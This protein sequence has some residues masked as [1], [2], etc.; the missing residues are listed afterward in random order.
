MDGAAQ[1]TAIADRL[2]TNPYVG[3]RAFTRGETLY[4]RDREVLDLIDLVVAERIVLL[5]SPSGAGKTSLLQAALIPAL[6]EQ[7]FVVPPIMRVGDEHPGVQ[8]LSPPPNRYV[9]SALSRLETAVPPDDQRS[10]AELASLSFTDY[11]DRAYPPDEGHVVFVI[12]QLEE[13]MTLDPTDAAVKVEFFRQLGEAL[14][15]RRR[16]AVLTLREDFVAALDPYIKAF[17]A[18]LS[19]RYRLDL[20]GPDAALV[21]ITAPAQA[22]GVAFDEEAA[23]ALVDDLRS[24][25][26]ERWGE[27]TAE[28]GPY[29]EPV[30]LQVAARQLWARRDPE[31]RLIGI[32]DVT[33]L[34]DL[35]DALGEYYDEQVDLVARGVDEQRA[36]RDWVDAKLITE[37]GFR[38]QA[39]GGPDG[40][41]AGDSIVRHLVDTHL[42]RSE[43]RRG[44]TWYELAHDRLVGPVRD[45]NA[46]WRQAHLD[47]VELQAALWETEGRPD[48]RLLAGTELE[49]GTRWADA[50]SGDLSP[51]VRDFLDRSESARRAR[52]AGRYKRI[53]LIA[54]VLAL[55][56]A[57]VA[58]FAGWL[59]ARAADD[60]ARATTRELIGHSSAQRDVDP[61]LSTLLALEAVD[62][63]PDSLRVDALAGLYGALNT[64]DTPVVDEFVAPTGTNVLAVA[65]APGGQ[66]IATAGA[67]EDG[68]VVIWDAATGQPLTTLVGHTDWVRAIA[69]APDGNTIATASDDMTAI[70]WDT[71]TGQPLHTLTG[72]TDW[73]RGIAYAPDGNTLAT[74]SDDMAAIIWDAATGTEV[75]RLQGHSDWLNGVAYAPDGN[76]IATA[77]DDTTAMIWDAATGQALTTLTQTSDVTR[78][79]TVSPDGRRVGMAG[80]VVGIYDPTDETRGREL[81]T[82]GATVTALAFTASGE[83][84]VSG[85]DTGAVRLWRA[86]TGTESRELYDA[87]GAIADIAASADER[88]VAVAT[89]RSPDVEIIDLDDDARWQ[90]PRQDADIVDLTFAPADEILAVA[91]ADGTVALWDVNDRRSITDLG[92]QDDGQVARLAS[93]GSPDSWQ[94]AAAYT[95]GSTVVLSVVGNEV[96]PSSVELETDGEPRAVAMSP[97]GS[98]LAV[99][100]SDGVTVA[101]AQG[102]WQP[103]ALETEGCDF[104]VPAGIGY[105]GPGVVAIASAD[106]GAQTCETAPSKAGVAPIYAV[107]VSP[108]GETIVA[109][110]GGGALVPWDLGAGMV[111]GAPYGSE[112]VAHTAW[113]ND[114]DVGPDGE[115][116]ASAG[117]DGQGAIWDASGGRTPLV[118]HTDWVLG[119]DLSPDGSRVATASRDGRVIVWDPEKGEP[120]QEIDAHEGGAWDVVFSPDGRRLASVGDDEVVRIWDARTG[121]AID[122]FR[123]ERGHSDVVYSVIFDPDGEL[124][125]TTS[126]DGTAVVW[127]A[128]EGEVVHRFGDHDG[129]V[130]SAAF[131]RDEERELLATASD[132]NT[133]LLYDLS[134]GDLERRIELPSAAYS[135]AFTPDGDEVVVGTHSG[136]I[137]VAPVDADEVVEQAQDRAGRELTPEECERFL[138]DRGC[139]DD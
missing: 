38:S 18:P 126:A 44:T 7:D 63:A 133:V 129:H 41:E 8:H 122:V 45:R 103:K 12:D 5:Y 116:V 132:D 14:R 138:H 48:H 37:H 20:L 128:A 9:L 87:D 96:S 121:E 99:A 106:G 39:A 19:R 89:A 97:S 124:L 72:H 125:A 3:P 67:G 62:R 136:R 69:Y 127:D 115:R 56:M 24:V 16:W 57:S 17:P 84:L 31:A 82:G 27:T 131:H 91:T 80:A 46:I 110:D 134:S 66:T 94:L 74:A 119:I 4:G 105:V 28:P 88:L 79:F 83:V 13:V 101:S 113:I 11:L 70:I 90:L 42:L 25:R 1:V 98:E 77:S 59:A 40:M 30:Q 47:P 111:P 93:A 65:Y 68:A 22:A 137:V 33:R 95:D 102:G 43:S 81:D 112:G 108:D 60:A 58:G 21:A 71:T 75:T 34:G 100:S 73:V 114:V 135:V 123:D 76:T 54:G 36:V 15:D 92:G 55:I 117:G 50:R 64:E 86:D 2:G 118:G 139:A 52:T 104:E 49:E 26:V 6:E 35:D 32:E 23:R 85:D 53:G 130:L 78:A 120:L 107:A 29:V 10:P 61:A 51:T 109:G